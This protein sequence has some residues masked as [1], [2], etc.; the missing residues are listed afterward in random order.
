MGYDTTSFAHHN[1]AI[2]YHS[3]SHLFMSQALSGWMGADARFQVSPEIF[4]SIQAQAV[5]G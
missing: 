1:L 5:A 3:S 4:D 2:I